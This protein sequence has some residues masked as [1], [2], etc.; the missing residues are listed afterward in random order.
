MFD[1]F[2]IGENK[3]LEQEFPFAKKVSTY[4]AKYKNVL[5]CRP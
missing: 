1:I 4:K 2:Y 3:L 5:D